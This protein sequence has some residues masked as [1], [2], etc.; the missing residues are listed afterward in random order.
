MIKIIN[1]I[2]YKIINFQSILQNGE[3]ILWLYWAI[4]LK[5]CTVHRIFD[6]VNAE[7]GSQ[8]AR[9]QSL[10]DLWV[11][12]PAEVPEFVNCIFVT[13]YKKIYIYICL[14]YIYYNFFVIF[15]VLLIYIN[16]CC[17]Y[18]TSNIMTGPLLV[19]SLIA[20]NSGKTPFIYFYLHCRLRKIHH[21]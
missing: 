8:S 14:Y 18:W 2:K 9:V 19:F 15:M 20:L 7:V 16:I 17:Y 10:G 21:M 12:R 13:N 3:E 6:S 5:V 11:V 4:F 1:N